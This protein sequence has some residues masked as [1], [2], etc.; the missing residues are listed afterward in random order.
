M[1]AFLQQTT[2][3]VKMC[4]CVCSHWIFTGSKN[5]LY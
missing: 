2:N 1:V 5:W 4:V 3:I